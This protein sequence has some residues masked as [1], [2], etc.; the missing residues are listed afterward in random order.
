MT[1]LREKVQN[2]YGEWLGQYDWSYFCT[3]T[4]RYQLTLPSARRLMFRFWDMD[5]IKRSGSSRFFWCAEP[6]D[7]RHGYHTHGLLLVNNILTKND[8]GSIYQVACGNVSK[9]K[10][11]WHRLQLRDYNEKRNASYYCGK[12]LT[13][14]LADYDIWER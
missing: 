10:A 9:S 8:L 1:N 14:Q 13:K 2:S 7:T 11:N 5:D 6:F 3:F 4:T 12:Y